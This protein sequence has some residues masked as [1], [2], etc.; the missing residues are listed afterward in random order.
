MLQNRGKDVVNAHV[1][2]YLY[3][4]ALLAPFHT[5]SL[6]ELGLGEFYKSNPVIPSVVGHL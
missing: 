3:A 4:H 1:S 6:F 5:T 2:L